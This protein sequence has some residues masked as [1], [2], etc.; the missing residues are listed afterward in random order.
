LAKNKKQYIL[1]EMQPQQHE[2]QNSGKISV[3][4]PVISGLSLLWSDKQWTIDNG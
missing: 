4:K 1:H 3:D 2:M